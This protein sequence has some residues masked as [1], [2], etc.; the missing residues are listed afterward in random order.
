MTAICD[1]DMNIIGIFTDGDLRRVFDTGVD[2]RDASIADVMTRGGIRIRPGTLAVDALNLMQSRHIT[3]VLVADG[4]HLLGVVHM[5][6]L[7]RA[8]VV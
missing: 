5:H 2:M 3:C 4:D 6:D 8:G 1:D 7:L